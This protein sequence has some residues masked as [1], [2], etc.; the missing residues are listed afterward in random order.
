LARFQR[1]KSS[2]HVG[3]V[4]PHSVSAPYKTP[5]VIPADTNEVNWY[6]K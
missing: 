4:P 2:L 6:Y 1:A 5:L 3:N